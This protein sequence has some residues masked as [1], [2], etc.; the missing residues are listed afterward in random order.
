M[1][2]AQLDDEFFRHPKARAAGKDG[3]VLYLAGLCYA[4]NQLTDGYIPR[5]ALPVVAAEA[6][7]RS[8]VARRLVDVGLWH[9]EGH[10]CKVCPQP[11]GV[12]WVIHGY[13]DWQTSRAE[14]EEKRAKWRDK[15]QGWRS[16]RESP[17]A[18]PPVSAV[19]T[20]GDTRSD[21]PGVSDHIQKTEDRSTTSPP[22]TNGCRAHTPEDDD[23]QKFAEDQHQ[24]AR[25]RAET[26]LAERRAEGATIRNPERWLET[27]TR[28]ELA[29]PT[30]ERPPGPDPFDTAIATIRTAIATIGRYGQRPQLDPHLDAAITHAGGWQTLCDLPAHRLE[31]ELRQAWTA[32]TKATA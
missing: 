23:E 20:P 28:N 3:R 17:P 10:D 11:P 2:Y 31:P 6:E 1:T 18:S 19:D 15:K 21:S 22:L 7:V 26:R 5:A 14:V 9:G 12:G 29:N 13:L 25:R 32:T 4:A 8:T 24:Q 30:P 16:R 27:A